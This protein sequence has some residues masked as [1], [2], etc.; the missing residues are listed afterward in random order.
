MQI[1]RKKFTKSPVKA[2]RYT[3]RPSRAIKAED[4]VFEEDVQIDE[5]IPEEGGVD[6]DPEATDLLFEAEDVAEL[7][8]EITGETVD[9]TVDEDVVVFSVGDA[10]YTVEAEGDEETVESS[11]KIAKSKKPVAAS[12]RRPARPARKPV[13]ASRN[14]R[15]ARPARPAH[16]K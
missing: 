8:A 3:R 6:V 7:V 13:A 11:R 10:D 1:K 5:E 14:A 12:T 4:E 16:R 2:S 15:P 9:V